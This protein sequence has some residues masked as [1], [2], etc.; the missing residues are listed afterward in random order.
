[1]IRQLKIITK[2]LLKYSPINST[3]NNYKNSTLQKYIR[4]SDNTIHTNINTFF[5]CFRKSIS[6]QCNDSWLFNFIILSYRNCRFESYT[7]TTVTLFKQ[8]FY[9][10]LPDI[11]GI[12]QS[13]NITLYLFLAISSTAFWPLSTIVKFT[14]PIL[15]IILLITF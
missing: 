12:I 1:M 14:N 7:Q 15:F 6:S 13:I 5:S 3:I 11:I 8:F 10:N 2:C 4:F 9:Q